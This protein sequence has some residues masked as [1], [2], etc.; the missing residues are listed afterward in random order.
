MCM[1]NGYFV[2]DCTAHVLSEV[3]THINLFSCSPWVHPLD[4]YKACKAGMNPMEFTSLYVSSIDL[5]DF[6]ETYLPFVAP[7]S[8]FAS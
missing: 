1:K 4:I 7:S 3:A 8:S 2:I 6:S 5:F